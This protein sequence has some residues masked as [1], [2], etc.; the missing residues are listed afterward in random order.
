MFSLMHVT[1]ENEF[2]HS[3][4]SLASTVSSV[5][6]LIVTGNIRR[7]LSRL[8]R[9]S[10]KTITDGIFIRSKTILHIFFAVKILSDF[11]ASGHKSTAFTVSE[12]KEVTK[13]P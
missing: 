8:I 3:T 2:K 6:S 9:T 10:L 11:I 1:R 12:H 5:S 13:S 7:T 4:L